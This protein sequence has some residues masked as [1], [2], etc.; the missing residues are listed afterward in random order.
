V[1]N[2]DDV[3]LCELD[4]NAS[5]VL[6]VT[7]TTFNGVALLDVRCWT[8]PTTPTAGD[9]KPTKK[10]LALRPELWAQ[11]LPILQAALY[12]GGADG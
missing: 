3:I 2:P 7:T 5:E 12:G 6:R 1:P 11:L 10:G 8:K 9:A 4:K